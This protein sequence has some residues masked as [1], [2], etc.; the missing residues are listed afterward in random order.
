MKQEQ[1]DLEAQA[2][3]KVNNICTYGEAHIEVKASLKMVAGSWVAIPKPAHKPQMCKE[4][5]GKYYNAKLNKYWHI[6]LKDEAPTKE[7]REKIIKAISTNS[8]EYRRFCFNLK[9]E[10]KNVK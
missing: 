7:K 4:D 1:V 9:K 6:M 8:I 5:A 10:V 3:S 2:K